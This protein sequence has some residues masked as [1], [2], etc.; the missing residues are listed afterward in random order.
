MI[1][2]R[3]RAFT[4]VELL[5]VIA[6]IGTLVALLLPAVQSAR[7]SGRRSSCLNNVRQLALASLEFE[8]RMRR[9][10]PLFDQTGPQQL[11]SE[12]GERFAT[13]AV[14]LLPDMDHQ[15]IFDSYAKGVLPMPKG[16]IETYLCPSD[17]SKQRSGSVVSYVANAGAGVSASLQRAANGPF[18]NRVYDPAAAV[19]EGHWKDGKDHTIA[20]SERTDVDAYDVMGWNGF[21]QNINDADGPVD[22]FVV[23]EKKEDRTWGP[24]F[25]W[26]AT[27]AQCAYINAE[28][29]GCS[30]NDNACMPLNGGPRYVASSCKFECLTSARSPNAKP[31]SDHGGGVNVAFGSG[32]AL[33]L[34]ETIDYTVYRALLTLNDKQSDSP[35]RDII[36]DDAA[37]Q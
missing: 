31:S 7:E 10:P 23:D 36:L 13:W 35:K 19:M 24:V 1:A 5:V 2:R 9:Y 17:S 26:H 30:Q 20:F 15:A 14:L 34:R 27:P 22:H 33:F 25:V 3:V 6:I 32:R 18:L 37:W 12:S 28:Q 4:L 16:Y 11:A 21:K 29:C 8:G